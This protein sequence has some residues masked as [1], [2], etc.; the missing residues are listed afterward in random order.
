VIAL[1]GL[2]FLA[3]G[4]III[5]IFVTAGGA[6]VAIANKE[7]EYTR[8][9]AVEDKKEPIMI[10]HKRWRLMNTKGQIILSTDDYI[11]AQELKKELWKK[12][13]QVLIQDGGK[14]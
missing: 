8:P 4:Y 5:G 11:Q 7:K 9:P 13:T 10:E 1:L 2:A 3:V 14:K 12:H 6:A